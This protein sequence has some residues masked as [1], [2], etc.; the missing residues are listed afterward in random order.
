MRVELCSPDP[1]VCTVCCF[2]QATIR[3]HAAEII[4]RIRRDPQKVLDKFDNGLFNDQ[5]AFPTVSGFRAWSKPH[6]SLKFTLT[7][8]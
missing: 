5:E 3:A 7:V 4:E 2:T 6:D 8:S 1:N